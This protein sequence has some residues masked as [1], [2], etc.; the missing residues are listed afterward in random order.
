MGWAHGSGMVSGPS[1]DMLRALLQAGST[2]DQL[3]EA[4]FAGPRLFHLPSGVMSTPSWLKG[5]VVSLEEGAGVRGSNSGKDNI[6]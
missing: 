5:T 1:L 2:T 6:D 4:T 3:G